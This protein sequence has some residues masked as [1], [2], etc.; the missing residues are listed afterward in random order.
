MRLLK[1]EE[2]FSVLFTDAGEEFLVLPAERADTTS[3]L[4]TCK[5]L[6][7]SGERLS[8]KLD[9]NLQV[10]KPS[11]HAAKFTLPDSFFNLTVEEIR[12]EQK[13]K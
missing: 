11:F 7:A 9:R 4:E 13:L 6:L 10:F 1:Y 3:D 12:R 2:L 8:L 5:E